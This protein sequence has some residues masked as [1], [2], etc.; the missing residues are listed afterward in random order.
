[1]L[2]GIAPLI[3]AWWS[4]ANSDRSLRQAMRSS[5]FVG[6]LAQFI[7]NAIGFHWIAMTAIE[8]GHFPAWAGGLTLFAFCAA[9]HLY[10]ALAGV[11]ATWIFR[12]FKTEGVSVS[13]PRFAFISIAAFAFCEYLWPSIFPWHLGYPW[14]WAK[15][16]GA[17]FADVIGFEGLNLVTLIC[18]GAFAVALLVWP[19]KRVAARWAT[20]ALAVFLIANGLGFG[21]DA[22]WKQNEKELKL[23]AVQGNIGNYEKLIAERSK[24]FA[25]PII[26]KYM[27]MT[28]Q[29]FESHPDADTVIWP[30]TAFP[31]YLDQDFSGNTNWVALRGF[32]QVRGKTI[33]TGAY[34]Y[35]VPNKTSYNGFFVMTNQGV[36]AQPTHRKSVLIPFGERFPFSDIIP[37]MKW[38]FPGLG[39]FGAGPGPVIIPT[40][41]FR[42]GP[43]ICLESL[44]P[45]FSAQLALK[46]AQIISNVTNDS[47]FGRTFEPYQHMTMTLAR[48]V[49]NRRPLLRSTN[50]G[51]TTVILA[52]G[53]VLERSPI[54][55][56]WSGYFHVPYK[57]NPP[58]ATYSRIAGYSPWLALV[59]LLSLLPWSALTRRKKTG[60]A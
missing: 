34:S 30:E 52:D 51:I 16:P 32:A 59:A 56:E 29:A 31:D 28:A 43:Q 20:A 33:L 6:W 14:L 23:I 44:Y 41:Q 21:R 25:V 19:D 36:L 13:M 10:Y 40:P 42:L 8:F 47:W 27:K 49:E 15:L 39:S 11:V 26:E 53:T 60:T 48:A 55:E 18:N 37:Y 9:A 24:D 54:A 3:A 4:I 57:E 22:F 38:L 2:F 5:F 58:I 1:M 46:G 7:L 35:D 17:Q 45:R 50:T 12:R